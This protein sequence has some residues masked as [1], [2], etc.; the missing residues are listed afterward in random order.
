MKHTK[1]LDRGLLP[2]IEGRGVGLRERVLRRSV[3][4]RCERFFCCGNG[5]SPKRF[6]CGF[7][8]FLLHD[9]VL[10]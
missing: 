6:V 8:P 10:A 9:A 5:G 4:D 7:T 2:E 1:N 3:A